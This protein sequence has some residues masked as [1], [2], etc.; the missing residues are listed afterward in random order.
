[1]QRVEFFERVRAAYR[2]R[3]AAY[4]ERIVVIDATAD[5]DQ[6]GAQILCALRDRSWIT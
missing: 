3:A 1:M 4:P 5:A 2:A 6:V